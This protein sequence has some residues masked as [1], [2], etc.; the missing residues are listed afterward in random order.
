MME[1][2]KS[3]KRWAEFA[4]ANPTV[5]D[6]VRQEIRERGPLRKR[7]LEGK[8]VSN[9]R[10][11]KDTGVALYYLWLTGELMSYGRQGKERIYDFLENVASAHLQGTAAENEAIHYFTR[12]A[13]SHLGF[14]TERDFLRILKS[15]TERPVDAKESKSKL[16]ELVEAG[17]L[18]TVRLENQKKPL[19]F[20]ASDAPLLEKLSDGLTPSEWHPAETTTSEEVVFFSPLEY[21]SARGRAKELFD[22]DYIW[23][24]YK[25]DHKRKYGPYTLPILYGDQLVGRIDAKLERPTETLLINGIWLEEWFEPDNAFALALANGLQRVAEFLEVKPPLGGRSFC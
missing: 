8:A 7:D 3:E 9:Y 13:I 5:L 19:Y 12:K 4:Q 23:E 15:V 25:P 20:L 1:R 16:A 17:E 2:R 14:V 11:S 6:D 24:I 10:G 22:F 21:V 18:G